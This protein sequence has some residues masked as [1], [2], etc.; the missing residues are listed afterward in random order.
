[1]LKL[2]LILNFVEAYNFYQKQESQIHSNSVGDLCDF[3]F[4]AT[5]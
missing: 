5:K 3:E 4:I 2:K 1:M